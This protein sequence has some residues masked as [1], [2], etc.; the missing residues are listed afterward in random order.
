[1]SGA[2]RFVVETSPGAAAE[3]AA[4]AGVHP[5]IGA[6]F[7]GIRLILEREPLTHPLVPGTRIHVAVAQKGAPRLRIFYEVTAQTVT[8]LRANLA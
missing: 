1:M 4:L 6:M 5:V 7:E 2:S 3:L 8:V